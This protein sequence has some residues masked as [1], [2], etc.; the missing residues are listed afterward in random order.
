ML[1]AIDKKQMLKN[2]FDVK[3]THTQLIDDDEQ[4]N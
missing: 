4:R 1:Y 3:R 2:I